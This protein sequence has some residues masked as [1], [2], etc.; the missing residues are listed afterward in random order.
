MTL[1]RARP[2]WA[3]KK[4]IFGCVE[5][6][7]TTQIEYTAV[8]SKASALGYT[9]P[10]SA[11]DAINNRI[12]FYLKYVGLWDKFDLFYFFEQESGLADFCTLNWKDPDNFQLYQ[13]TPSLKPD[14]VAGSGF[15]G[16]SGKFW[17]TGYLPRTSKINLSIND[18]LMLTKIFGI[19]STFSSITD[20][21][22]C[23][24]SNNNGQIA[25][26]NNSSGQVLHRLFSTWN[27]SLSQ[28]NQNG[29]FMALI[30]TIGGLPPSFSFPYRVVRNKTE[31]VISTTRA[32]ESETNLTT[33][34]LVLHAFNDNG[35][36]FQRGSGGLGYFALG[37][38]LN[39]GELADSS[40][41]DEYLRQVFD[42]LNGTY[43]YCT[44]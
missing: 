12:I 8:R 29:Q 20:I 32:T 23:R 44:P 1:R 25:I 35:T 4:N 7:V 43:N 39:V 26:L 24:N 5:P 10:S 33:A 41:Y 30:N 17:R 15:Q 27:G 6:T 3:K 28:L 38:A 36:V 16:G 14:F 42:I 22:G 40:A 37:S 21:A 2:F 13:P 31:V 19:P 11:Q 18:A 34:E 9:L